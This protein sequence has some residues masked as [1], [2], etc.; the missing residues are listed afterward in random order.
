MDRASDV[1]HVRDVIIRQVD[2]AELIAGARQ[3]VPVRYLSIDGRT[4]CLRRGWAISIGR[5]WGRR[6]APAIHER[7]RRRG[8]SSDRDATGVVGVAAAAAIAAAAAAAAG[9]KLRSS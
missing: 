3:Q 6:R 7:R 4:A 2:P 8:R 9:S 5:Q 1:R